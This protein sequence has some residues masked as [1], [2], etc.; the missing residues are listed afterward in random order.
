MKTSALLLVLV[1]L[2][3]APVSHAARAIPTPPPLRAALNLKGT[4]VLIFRQT[5][6]GKDYNLDVSL[7]RLGDGSVR[8]GEKRFVQLVIYASKPNM[9]GGNDVIFTDTQQITDGTSNITDGTS[10]TVAFAPFKASAVTAAL[11]YIEQDNRA[12]IIAILIG[13]KQVGDGAFQPTALPGADSIVAEVNPGDGGLGLLLPA[14][15]KVRAAAA[16]L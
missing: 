11:P 16:R 14:V 12:G 7:L 5:R 2:L 9:A 8:P 3:L 4:D 15:Q 6:I 10:N 1:S 13:Y